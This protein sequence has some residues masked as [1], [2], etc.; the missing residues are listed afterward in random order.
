MVIRGKYIFRVAY[1]AVCISCT[2]AMVN[3]WFYKFWIEDRDIAAVD[4]VSL[5]EAKDV[6]I[7]SLAICFQVA[8]ITRFP[9]IASE[10]NFSVQ[11]KA[12]IQ[13]WV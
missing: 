1:S 12:S 10:V 6:E 2:I 7:P 13:Q 9:A 5:N 8:Q 11:C 3:Y 4:V